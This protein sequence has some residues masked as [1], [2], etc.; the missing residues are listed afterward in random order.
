MRNSI[1]KLIS[2]GVVAANK[3]LSSM[4]IEVSPIEQLPMLDGEITDNLTSE[5]NK[6]IDADGASYEVN[7]KSSATV[8]ARWLPFGSNRKTA[9]DVRRGEKVCIWQYGDADKYYWS[10]LEYNGKLRKKETVIFMISNTSV[11]E[12]EPT[13]D[14]TY[15]F[16]WSTH[17]KLLQLHTSTNDGE[18]YGYDFTINTKAGNFQFT[19]TI[20]NTIFL[21][22]ASKRIVLKNA[23]DTS[24]DLNAESLYIN[25]VKDYVLKVGGNMTTL[26]SGNYSAKV[27][28]DYFTQANKVDFVTPTFTTSEN[29]NAGGNAVIG[30]SA[31]VKM[32]LLIGKGM[33]TG[34]DGGGGDIEIA[35]S[36][37]LNGALDC[38]STGKFAGNV[39][40]PNI[41]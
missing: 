39:T 3:P 8:T 16:L 31:A 12:E 34:A 9:P 30:G 6:G 37:K 29:F 11:E 23:A 2:Y 13:L 24:F 7:T 40:A 41:R 28:G 25:V 38:T 18:P 10:E 22:S 33:K 35:G 32:G 27:D 36:M 17:D 20:E 21:D 26:V 19:D 15:F 4:N 5:T 14:N 1:L